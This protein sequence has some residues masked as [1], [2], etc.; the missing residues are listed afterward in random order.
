[1]LLYE[2]AVAICAL[3]KTVSVCLFVCLFVWRNVETRSCNICCRGI[4]YSECVSV[5]IV[6]QHAK[7]IFVLLND[8][9][10]H[11]YTNA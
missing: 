1:M 7:H 9:S 5:A 2:Q 8:I 11:N 4:T 6:I 3:S 10:A